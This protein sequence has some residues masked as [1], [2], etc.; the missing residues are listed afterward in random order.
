M[1]RK[2]LAAL[3]AGLALAIF[4]AA[5][6]C[7]GVVSVTDPWLKPAPI[8]GTTRAYFVLGS[9]T[10]AT[11][12]TV[13]SPIAEVV[14]MQGIRRV[15]G[16]ALEPGRPLAMTQAGPHLALRGVAR[17]LKLGDRVPLTLTLRDADGRTQDVEVSAEVRNRSAYEDE[18]R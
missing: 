15:D 9:S 18:R 8:K 2:P 16:I 17:A 10:A 13:R 6:W 14:L 7:I 1:Q 12:V 11:L 3:A 4:A 5:A